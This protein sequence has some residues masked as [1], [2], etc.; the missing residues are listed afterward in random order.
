MAF[1]LWPFCAT[2]FD[3]SRCTSSQL[4]QQRTWPSQTRQTSSRKT[5]QMPFRP[6]EHLCS[7]SSMCSA[8]CLTYNRTPCD[9]R[10]LSRQDLDMK[11][12]QV[13]G[14]SDN[15]IKFLCHLP[16]LV[17]DSGKYVALRPSITPDTCSIYFCLGETGAA[18]QEYLI[19]TPSHVVWL[20][21]AITRDRHC[22]LLDTLC[23]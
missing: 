15:A 21:D 17:H 4:S 13:R 18:W 8:P 7:T 9:G 23:G 14:K 5:L 11:T 22:L 6:F 12:L 3:F 1:W 16:C 2:P 20:T 19:Q 10:P